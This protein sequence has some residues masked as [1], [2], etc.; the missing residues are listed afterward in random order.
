VVDDPTIRK[1]IGFA[2]RWGAGSIEVVNLFAWRAT[3]PDELTYAAE[4]V[5]PENDAVLQRRLASSGYAHRVVAWGGGGGARAR[6]RAGNL[7]MELRAAGI[8]VECLGVTKTGVPLHPLMQPY[9]LALRPWRP[10]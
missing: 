1:C 7:D 2:K 6:F 8:S 5:G 10:T 4:P 9:R 3:D